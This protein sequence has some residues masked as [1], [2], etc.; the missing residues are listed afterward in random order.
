MLSA[1]LRA[2]FGIVEHMNYYTDA[3]LAQ[4]VTRS[5]S[6][7]QRRSASKEPW[8]SRAGSRGTPRVANRLLKRVRDFAQVAAKEQID[9]EIVKFALE[10]LHVDERGLDETDHK[11]LRTMIELYGGG[12]VG[13]NTL[14][15][16]IG[17]DTETIADMI[18]PY[19]LQIGFIKRTARGRVV[20]PLAYEHLRLPYTKN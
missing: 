17:E 2:R 18:E 14:A 11:V 9:L 19:L 13:L 4:I 6:V 16:N 20:T 3:E 15:A 8:R 1:P 12:P 5:A 10:M 7:F